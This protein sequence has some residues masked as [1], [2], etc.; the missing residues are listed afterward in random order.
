MNVR[1]RGIVCCDVIGR[2]AFLDLVSFETSVFVSSKRCETTKFGRLMVSC[3]KCLAS[4]PQFEFF[5]FVS[6]MMLASA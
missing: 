4:L 3:K 6:M 2:A 1:S 5:V